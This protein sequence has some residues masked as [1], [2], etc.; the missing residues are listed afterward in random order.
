MAQIVR[1][2]RDSSAVIVRNDTQYI[3][4]SSDLSASEPQSTLAEAAN[5]YPT[6]AWRRPVPKDAGA[7]S[8]HLALLAG[9]SV[10]DDIVVEQAPKA[11]RSIR[12]PKAMQRAIEANL[13][14]ATLQPEEYA[15]LRDL[16]QR[17]STTVSDVAWLY[18]RLT[19]VR[20]QFSTLGGDT[21]L[22]WLE[23]ITKS[24]ITASGGT[25]IYDEELEYFG[26][27]DSEESSEI[28]GLIAVD[29]ETGVVLGWSGTEFT[30]LPQSV[31]EYE[32]EYIVPLDEDSVNELV[33]R[34][35]SDQTTDPGEF[36]TLERNLFELAADELDWQLIDD[37]AAII[38][39]ATG[40]SPVERSNNASRQQRSMDGKF[41]GPQAETGTELT[42]FAKAR[43]VQP[44]PLVE[45]PASRIAE[46]LGGTSQA[47]V[48]EPVVPEEA[49]SV[50]AAASPV[51]GGPAPLYFAL[52]DSTDTTAV[53]DVVAIVADEAGQPSAWIRA[54][55]KWR[56]AP[57]TLDDLQGVTPPPVVELSTEEIARE[58]L[59]QVD[60]YD[61]N[62][63]SEDGR[64]SA[65]VTVT[66]SAS[67]FYSEYGEQ[68]P[69]M[70]AAG[71]PGIADTPSD[72]A[73]A[74]RLR[75]YWTHGPGAAKIR[76]GT[77]G[78]L[79]RAH[80]QLAKYVG[81]KRAWGL[82]QN[83]HKYLFGVP[84]AT[85]DKAMGH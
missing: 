8:A 55:G 11:E 13:N 24:S 84:N 59:T 20:D 83:Y 19:S 30:S 27:G 29:R 4:V 77:E 71:I 43:L 80:R 75:E 3:A 66:A 65:P 35:G 9:D 72:K 82:A 33:T 5:L 63:P 68:L 49:E 38:A 6:A 31:D 73:A 61:T 14:E 85:R 22:T 58:I 12:L 47:P 79:T 39:D 15:R 54:D 23:K 53:L 17:T 32:A 16:S 50:L 18:S 52:V 74:S 57:Q 2:A 56:S 76:W 25:F 45:D 48:E 42:A 41:G 10:T 60:Q 28:T 78:D 7:F 81:P 67:N 37:T 70:I 44:L 40:Y 34:L 69:A 21:A 1:V 36:N 46:Y 26:I 51:E 62:A 64:A